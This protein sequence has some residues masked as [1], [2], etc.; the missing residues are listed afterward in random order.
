LKNNRIL[1]LGFSIAGLVIAGLGF[2]FQGQKKQLKEAAPQAQA[3]PEFEI[4]RQLFH[5]HMAMRKKADEL[6][7]EGKNGR[8]LR[9]FYQEQARLTDDEARAFDEIASRCEQEVAKQD[10]K[11]KAIID[12][13]RARNGNGKLTKDDSPPVPPPEL[14]SLW[15]ERNAIVTRAKYALQ[16]AFGDS[17]FARFENYVNHDVVPQ[18][19]VAPNHPRPTP[20]GPKHGPQVV[21]APS[22]S[23]QG[24]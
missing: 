22:P 20:M 6:E 24:M 1:L 9:K 7:K 10:A 2:N 16:A 8:F 4:Y 5:H 18:F 15:D 19:V 23:T 17:E 21:T 12:R 13:L 11:A 14:R 3:I